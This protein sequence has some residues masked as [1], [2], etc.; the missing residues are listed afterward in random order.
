MIVRIPCCIALRRNTLCLAVCQGLVRD[1]LLFLDLQGSFNHGDGQASGDVPLHVAMQNPDARV[2][3]PK[4]HDGVAVGRNHHGVSPHG[5]SG[6]DGVCAV[7]GVRGSR[8]AHMLW[9]RHID[10]II[11]SNELQ[12]MAM[13]I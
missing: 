10:T 3:G 1:L 8:R 13:H 2:V 12:Y 9:T 11:T 4:S 6:E 7:V 5:Y